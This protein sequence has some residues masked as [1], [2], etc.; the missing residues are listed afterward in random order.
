MMEDSL[1]TTGKTGSMEVLHMRDG[2]CLT[3]TVVRGIRWAVG[4]DASCCRGSNDAA[5]DPRASVLA[6]YEVD[7]ALD[8]ADTVELV[9]RLGEESILVSTL[10]FSIFG[11]SQTGLTHP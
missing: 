5:L 10:P 8:V 3:D 11:S 7:C 2:G 1:I 9:A 6:P 4:G